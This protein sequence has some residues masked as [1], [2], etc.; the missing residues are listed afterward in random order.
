MCAGTGESGFGIRR[1]RTN[2]GLRTTEKGARA[3]T[4]VTVRLEI[5]RE[6][7]KLKVLRRSTRRRG[8][9]EG[10]SGIDREKPSGADSSLRWDYTRLACKGVGDVCLFLLHKAV[11]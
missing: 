6:R 1:C 5:A 3:V 11:R 7:E 4:E 10:Y 8:I 2:Y 9:D